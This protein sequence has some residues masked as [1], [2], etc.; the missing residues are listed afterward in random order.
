MQYRKLG[1]SG[2]LVSELC[3]GSMSFGAAGYWE[4]IGGLDQQAAQRL[5]DIAL[6]AGVNFLIQPMS[7]RTVN[8]K[9]SSARRSGRDV[10]GSCSPP[11]CAGA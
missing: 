2:L 8:P 6:D 5:V 1:R 7:I 10:I 4:K 3:F 9:K 11:R